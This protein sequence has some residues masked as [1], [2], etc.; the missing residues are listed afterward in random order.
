MSLSTTPELPYYVDQALL[1]GLSS[2]IKLYLI[3]QGWNEDD[4]K[5][6]AYAIQFWR[7]AGMS[8]DIDTRMSKMQHCIAV[9]SA[10]KGLKFVL[11][12]RLS[13]STTGDT[14]PFISERAI[15]KAM[16]KRLFEEADFENFRYEVVA[17]H[18]KLRDISGCKYAVKHICPTSVV[19][20]FEDK[21]LYLME[22]K[23]TQPMFF[24]D[25][26]TNPTRRN[27]IKALEASWKAVSIKSVARYVSYDQ[28]NDVYV[29][30]SNV[31]YVELAMSEATEKEFREKGGPSGNIKIA[32][33]SNLKQYMPGARW[34]T[35]KEDIKALVTK[36]DD[37]NRELLNEGDESRKQ[38]L[39]TGFD[40]LKAYCKDK[41]NTVI[42]DY[43]E[44]EDLEHRAAGR[45]ASV[46]IEVASDTEMSDEPL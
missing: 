32:T 9:L 19:V 5:K 25:P 3:E 42:V 17:P 34:N 11:P 6:L 12:I 40:Q 39:R 20:I 10:L 37:D 8:I 1:N 38:K 2:K 35:F 7:A 44:P 18:V 21:M 24:R 16:G 4:I 28:S 36:F 26:K 43:E 15:R 33:Q 29:S 31:V 14:D 27:A 41:D 46:P 22:R 30:S 45:A 23:S 13:A